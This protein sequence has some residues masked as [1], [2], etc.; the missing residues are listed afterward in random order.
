MLAAATEGEATE[1]QQA[2]GF[3]TTYFWTRYSGVCPDAFRHQARVLIG[4]GS[5][6]WESSMFDLTLQ[7]RANAH[8]PATLLELRAFFVGQNPA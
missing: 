6:R 4:E 1:Q 5:R 7:T 2:E 8:L 3:G